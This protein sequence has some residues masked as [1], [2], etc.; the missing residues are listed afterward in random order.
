MKGI[1]RLPSKHWSLRLPSKHWSLRLP[2]K[3]WS[4]RLP[5]KHRSLRLP[6]QYDLPS[7]ISCLNVFS[8]AVRRNDLLSKRFYTTQSMNFVLVQIKTLHI[9]VAWRQQFHKT[10]LC[11]SHY[12][13][14]LCQPKSQDWGWTALF[15][16]SWVA[17]NTSSAFKR[18]RCQDQ[19]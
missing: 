16:R 5:S 12:A 15:I 4:L 1:L 2:S 7:W 14:C 19:V 11:W 10:L 6:S 17:R 3:H 18:Q 8:A 9:V 13:W